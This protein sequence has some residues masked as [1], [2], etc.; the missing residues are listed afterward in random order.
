MNKF[1]KSFHRSQKG[2]T[3]IEL[4]IVVVILGILAAVI[5]PNVSSFVKKGQIAAANAELAQVGT[6]GQ[7]AA[8]AN[9]AMAAFIATPAAPGALAPYLQGKLKGTY[10]IMAD[11]SI[12]VSAANVPTYIPATIVYDIPTAQFK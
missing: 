5:I 11:G 2:F 12:D 1:V 4:L 7:A 6:A 10:H 9:T 3:L 8:S